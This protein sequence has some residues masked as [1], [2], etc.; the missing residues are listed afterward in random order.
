MNPSKDMWRKKKVLVVPSWY[1]SQ[2]NP[3]NGV[4][5]REQTLALATEYDVAVLIPDLRSWRS[6]FKSNSKE[7]SSRSLDERGVVVYREFTRPLIPH[8]PESTDYQ[9]FVRAAHKGYGKLIKEWGRP[10]IIHAHVVLP[11]GWSAVNLG[12]RYGIPVVLTEH[13]G[14]FSMHLTTPFQ[15]KLVRQTLS[16]VDIV[17][18]NSP[19]L[20]DQILEFHKDVNL[21]VVGALVGTDFFVPAQSSNGHHKSTTKFLFVGRLSEEKGVQYLTKAAHGL[22]ERG[23]TSFELILAGDGRERASLE[24]L[25]EKLGLR[26]KCTFP[27]S[28]D[29]ESVRRYMQDCDVFVLPS[30][31]ETF[32][33]VVGEAM[34]CGKPVIATRCGGPEFVVT[35]ETGLLVDVANPDALAD[36]MLKFINGS[37]R[38]DEA[39]IR[40]SVVDR[41]GE[42]TFIKNISAV[43]DAVL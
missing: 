37:V 19:A 36:A 18:A 41:F 10:D 7:L 11:G 15:Q 16:Q 22:M 4:F 12:K 25:V 35:N 28:L 24:G 43:Y 23:V 1:P 31:I 6:L 40:S 2:D 13:S 3:I 8:G 30:L 9:T 29:R 34:A 5:V 38:F 21:D 26:G 33:I 42:D 32:G 20:A 14:P 39:T 17:L 27:G